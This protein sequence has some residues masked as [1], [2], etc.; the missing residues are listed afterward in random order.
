VPG[1][2]VAGDTLLRAIAASGLPRAGDDATVG[3]PD[4]GTEHGDAARDA[5]PA[6]LA[7]Y[8]WDQLLAGVRTQRMQ[9]LLARAVADGVLSVTE[10]QRAEV[11]GLQRDAMAWVASNERA[12][13]ATVDHLAEGDVVAVVLK[14]AAV[15]HL[16]Y[17][18]PT[19]RV[20]GDADVLLPAQR[21]EPAVDLL[22]DAGFERPGPEPRRGVHGRIGREVE[23]VGPEGGS[24]GLHVA[25]AP[26]P[27]A[28][29]IDVD[30]LFG[31]GDTFF[32]AGRQL[33]GLS[34]PWRFLQAC[35]SAVLGT[36]PVR[37]VPLRDAAGIATADGFDWRTAV[38]L[39]EACQ[40]GAVMARAVGLAWRAFGLDPEHPLAGWAV[41]R[42]ESAGEHELLAP[43]S[44]ESRRPPKGTLATLRC[45]D[46]PGARARYLRAVLRPG[47]T[48]DRAAPGQTDRPVPGWLRRRRPP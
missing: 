47:R 21:L 43:F 24:I 48:G 8:A 16:D 10:A 29:F 2:T 9:G 34:R 40:G 15:A 41:D 25:V 36:Q 30:E 3:G 31:N 26:E 6:L 44:A 46:A 35:F 17:P 7:G 11:E 13:L 4:D 12:L 28:L 5:H 37:L 1:V 45:L 39:A 33:A 32:V 19:M 20:F 18:D 42:P 22:R 27:F 14:G 38:E 23:L